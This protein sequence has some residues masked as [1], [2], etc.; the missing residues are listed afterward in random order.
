MHIV[1]DPPLGVQKLVHYTD[2]SAQ[3]KFN[4]QSMLAALSICLPRVSRNIL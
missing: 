2:E 1:A 3:I 4:T